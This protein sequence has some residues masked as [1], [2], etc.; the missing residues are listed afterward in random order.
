M[1]KSQT[2]ENVWALLHAPNHVQYVTKSFTEEVTASGR[3]SWPLCRY[4]YGRNVRLHKA[5]T[6]AEVIH[7]AKLHAWRISSIAE[8]CDCTDWIHHDLGGNFG[9]SRARFEN[10][11]LFITDGLKGMVGAWFYFKA[12][13]QHCCV[14]VSRNISHSACRWSSGSC[15][16]FKMVYQASSKRGA[17]S[18][19]CFA[20][21]GN[22]LS[23]WLNR[24]FFERSLASLS[25]ISLF[26]IIFIL[27]TWLN[28]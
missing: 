10:V 26:A 23:R 3:V 13:F 8:L 17:R 2:W 5:E 16:D 9:P 25:M 21:K 28:P 22:Q 24:F 18:T 11:L 27:R 15:D 12:R 7:I 14:H 6:V 20:E 1:S 19:W 4:L